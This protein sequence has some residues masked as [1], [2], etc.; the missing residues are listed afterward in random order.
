MTGRYRY[1]SLTDERRR[2]VG[3]AARNDKTLNPKPYTLHPK[4]QTVNPNLKP[5]TLNSKL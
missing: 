5:Q 2:G 3:G 4:P 1:R